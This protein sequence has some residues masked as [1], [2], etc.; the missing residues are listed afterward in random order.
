MYHCNEGNTCGTDTGSTPLTTP[1]TL[2]Y[3]RKVAKFTNKTKVA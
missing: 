2:Y 3:M 1:K